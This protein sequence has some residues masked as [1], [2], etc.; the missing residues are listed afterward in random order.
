MNDYLILVLPTLWAVWV[1]VTIAKCITRCTPIKY[2]NKQQR[3]Y[4]GRLIT[5]KNC[6]QNHKNKSK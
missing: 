3:D 6:D 5:V 2:G 4:N 1:A